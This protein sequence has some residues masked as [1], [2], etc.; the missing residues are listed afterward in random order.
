[1]GAKV[2]RVDSAL[3]D[4]AAQLVRKDLHKGMENSVPLNENMIMAM[5]GVGG[6]P[7]A[8]HGSEEQEEISLPDPVVHGNSTGTGSLLPLL[9]LS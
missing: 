1:M 5:G 4:A 6:R 7:Q 9:S 2:Y 3:Q 8:L